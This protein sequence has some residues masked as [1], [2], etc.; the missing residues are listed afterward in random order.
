MATQKKKRKKWKKQNLKE[1][2][3]PHKIKLI[4]EA[5]NQTL[6]IKNVEAN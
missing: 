4:H 2:S 6:V 1:K 5:V 3:C